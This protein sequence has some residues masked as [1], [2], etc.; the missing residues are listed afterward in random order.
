MTTANSSVST[1]GVEITRIF[2]APRELVWQA[3]TDPKHM[4]RWWGPKGFTSPACSIDLRVG[5]KYLFC[6]QAPD[7]QQIWS[8]GVYQEIVAL[9]QLVYTDSFADAAGNRV[10]ASYYGMG[11]EIPFEMTI[12][13]TFEALDDKTKMTVQHEGLPPGEMS[14]MTAA[15]WH[16]S[17]DKLAKS[18]N[19]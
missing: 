19:V 13:V 4:M 11:D 3:W 15:G 5:G 16:E 2:D 14:E 10:P 12:T 7:G 17:F 1:R 8:T 9:T 18:L 6:M